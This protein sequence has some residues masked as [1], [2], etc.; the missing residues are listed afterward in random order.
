MTTT[1]IT[2]KGMTCSHCEMSIAEEIKKIDG[3][4]EVSVSKD[5]GKAHVQATG[6]TNEQLAEAVEEAGY[7]ALEFENH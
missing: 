3:V 1:D 6:V 4:T 2:I 5:E 7:E